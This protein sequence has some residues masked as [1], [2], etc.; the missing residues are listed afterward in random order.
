MFK[1]IMKLIFIFIG[2]FLLVN[3][4]VFGILYY[5]SDEV[6]CNFIFCEFTKIKENIINQTCYQDGE[7][8]DCKEIINYEELMKNVE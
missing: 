3:V 7:L 4:I 2:L 6:N 5:T 8:I 1:P